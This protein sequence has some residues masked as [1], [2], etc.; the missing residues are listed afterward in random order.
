MLLIARWIV[1]GTC[2]PGRKLA[3][4]YGA[5]EL[6]ASK[7]MRSHEAEPVKSQAW[8]R[9]M[10]KFRGTRS[11]SLPIVHSKPQIYIRLHL[12]VLLQ[13]LSLKNY[14]LP[15]TTHPKCTS[16]SP[17]SFS[18]SSPSQPRKPTQNAQWTSHAPTTAPPSSMPTHATTSSAGM[19]RR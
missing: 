7:P 6:T 4:R 11:I 19:R 18:S 12:E 2:R 14:L 3:L 1:T 16:P 13:Q 10:I 9:S 5:L 17:Q 8:N 15:S